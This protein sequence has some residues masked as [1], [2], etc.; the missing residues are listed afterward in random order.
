MEY[1]KNG[2]LQG[3]IDN[4][5]SNQKP[6]PEIQIWKF[7]IELCRGLRFL[8]LNKILHGDLTAKNILLGRANKIKIGD[9]GLS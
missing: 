1:Y 2:S 5:N 4:A 6:I 3:F 9:F 7:L 8:H